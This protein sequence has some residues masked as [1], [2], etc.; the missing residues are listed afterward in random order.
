MII[1]NVFSSVFVLFLCLCDC[2]CRSCSPA[3]WPRARCAALHMSSQR[4]APSSSW[5]RDGTDLSGRSARI[6]S[7]ACHHPPALLKFLQTFNLSTY[8]SCFFNPKFS[9]SK[10]NKLLHCHILTV[11]IIDTKV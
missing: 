5:R 6:S 7:T 8:L 3:V 2:V 10:A 1:N 4:K 11:P 9:V